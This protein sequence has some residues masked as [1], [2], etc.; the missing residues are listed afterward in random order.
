VQGSQLFKDAE[1]LQ[2]TFWEAMSAVEQGTPVDIQ[3]YAAGE[4]AQPGLGQ[5]AGDWAKYC[6]KEQP[7]RQAAAATAQ[8]LDA[9]PPSAAA[10]PLSPPADGQCRQC[11]NPGLRQRH[12]CSKT[13]PRSGGQPNRGGEPRRGNWTTEQDEELRALVAFDA[14]FAS[15]PK[16]VEKSRAFSV[17]TRTASMLSHRWQRLV[18]LGHADAAPPRA[19]QRQITLHACGDSFRAAA[20]RADELKSFPG[21]EAGNEMAGDPRVGAATDSG[22]LNSAG[23]AEQK[24]L[25]QWVGDKP[26]KGRKSKRSESGEPKKALSAFMY[27]SMGRRPI[28][29][30]ENPDWAFGDFGKVMGAEWGKMSDADKA[31]YTKQAESDKQRYAGEKVDH[32]QVKSRARPLPVI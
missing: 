21:F 2:D 3:A 13:S 23:T 27:F 20:A 9:W 1:V 15:S 30:E 18:E 8:P 29:K 7:A 32:E 11:T 19:P 24:T 17:G 28:L 4:F 14:G 10:E 12:T 6:S 22:A 5:G 26:K 31:P 25:D 16:W